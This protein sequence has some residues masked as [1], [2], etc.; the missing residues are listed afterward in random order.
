VPTTSPTRPHDLIIEKPAHINQKNRPVSLFTQE[1]KEKWF[2]SG[3]TAT[4]K[5]LGDSEM[6][7]LL[8]QH[9]SFDSSEPSV[10]TRHVLSDSD[11]A[12]NLFMLDLMNESPQECQAEAYVHATLDETGKK[13]LFVDHVARESSYID[14]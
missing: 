5:E 10:D 4:A 2:G 6:A 8:G 12:D 7:G 14:C 13:K 1:A 11:D 9:N 3:P